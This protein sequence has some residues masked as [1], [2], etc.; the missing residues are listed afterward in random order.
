MHGYGQCM[1]KGGTRLSCSERLPWFEAAA[2]G[3]P[4]AGATAPFSLRFACHAP[5]SAD[6]DRLA[7][8]L[9]LDDAAVALVSYHI[10]ALGPSVIQSP[11]PSEL[12]AAARDAV[13][14]AA[15]L[16]LAEPLEVHD[17]RQPALSLSGGAANGAFSAGF[18]YALLWMRETARAHANPAQV[19]LLDGERF[20][21]A[22]GS[23]VG[24]LIS[25][26][27]DLY[28]TD[29]K[30]PPEL[31]P[32]ID[33]CIRM[34]GGKVAPHGDRPLQKCALA[35]LEHNF[36]ANEWDLL[37]ARDGSALDLLKPRTKSILKFD[38]LD[39]NTLVP[40]FRAFGPLT[41]ENGFRRTLITADLGQGVIGAID[42][43]ACRLPGI[44]ADLCER[45]AV[46]ASVSEPIS[47]PR[48]SASSRALE[49]R[50]A[51]GVSGSTVDCKA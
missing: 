45:E 21:S 10:A 47:P 28:F 46:L 8:A 13:G 27:L 5:P 48:A 42:E 9:S 30:P 35:T 25:L 18:M 41:R 17:P 20:T 44:N 14:H 39:Q 40:F 32:T 22:A 1:A 26:P 33:A 43:R 51:S 23:S 12:L 7:L 31:G 50:P 36:V 11:P 24:A 2:R 4:D 19:A 38:P 34:G 15:R 49:E 16:L 3:R 29:A 6:G 37:C